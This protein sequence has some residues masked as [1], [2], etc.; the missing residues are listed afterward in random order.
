MLKLANFFC[1]GQIVNIL[2]FARQVVSVAYSFPNPQPFKNVKTICRETDV[3]W[4]LAHG[5]LVLSDSTAIHPHCGAHGHPMNA[6]C[7]QR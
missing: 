3:G 4:D 6:P 2:G 7:H 5:H 1:K